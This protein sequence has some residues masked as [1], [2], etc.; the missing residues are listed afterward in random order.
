MKEE[1]IMELA[2]EGGGSEYFRVTND[3]G[4]VYYTYSISDSFD[5]DDFYDKDHKR[6]VPKKFDTFEEAFEDLK[7]DTGWY[8]LGFYD[9][10]DDYRDNIMDE[11]LSARDNDPR[12][13]N[14]WYHD[15]G[16]CVFSYGDI[17]ECCSL[18]RMQFDLFS[19][20]D[21]LI[22]RSYYTS[23]TSERN[24]GANEITPRSQNYKSFEEFFEHFKS[25]YPWLELNYNVHDEFSEYVEAEKRKAI[26]PNQD[27]TVYRLFE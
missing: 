16:H 25:N 2:C 8:K 10:H 4:S 20:N 23:A 27:T 18:Y 19:K 5:D 1:I 7:K 17:K 22:F 12:Y 6:P 24:T 9:L 13:Y 14:F 21:N 26:S 3:D 11:V 15:K